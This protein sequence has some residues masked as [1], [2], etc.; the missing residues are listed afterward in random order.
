LLAAGAAAAG[1]K[2][3]E[4][5]RREEARRQMEVAAR[6]M[7]EAAAKMGKEGAALGMQ[8][9]AKGME[10]AAAGMQGAAEAM[11]KMAGTMGG[12]AAAGGAKVEPVD[13]RE[14][15]ALL[16]ETLANLKRSEASGEKTGAMG[17]KVSQS[18]A[19]YKGEGN[20]R[21][22]LKIVDTGGLVGPMAF[23]AAGLAMVEID[24]ETEDGYEKTSTLDGRKSFEKWNSRR[25]DAELKVLVSNRFIV[26]LDGD[27]LAMDD[28]KAAAKQIDFAKL[29]S[30]AARA[31]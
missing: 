3:E 26:E 17:F 15:K 24:K 30:L 29:E 7:A 14:L 22:A 27:D 5:K 31:P 11:R 28:L 6:Q 19:R 21:L 25:K 13:F 20:T 9:A 23:A 16:P 4:E 2:S 10:G 8:G 12:G 18:R 1:C